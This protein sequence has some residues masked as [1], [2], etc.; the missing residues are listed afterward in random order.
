MRILA[1]SDLHGDAKPLITY[2]KDNKVDLIIIAGDITH[3]GPGELAEDIL[4]ALSTFQIPVLAIPGNCDPESVY[5]NIDNS[6]AINLHARNMVVKNI[7]LCGFGGSNPTPF[8]T[9]LEF[10]EV[11]IYDEAKK[12][13]ESIK[14]EKITLFITHA[15]PYGTKT[16]L[17]PSG[18]HVGSTSLRKIIEELQPTLNICGHIHEARGIDKIG[19]TLIINP[20]ELSDGYA[21]LIKISDSKD[22]EK[23][24]TGII[25]L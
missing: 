20:G 24:E 7:G 11:Q 16:D 23:I 22:K 25:K 21:C 2:L 12:T 9:P 15:P 18:E 8:N 10:E 19:K 17:L 3:F 14:D 5:A 4:N 13:L 1:V 6:P